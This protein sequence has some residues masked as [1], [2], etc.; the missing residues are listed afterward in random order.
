MFMNK[1]AIF[2]VDGT[3]FNGNL[4]IEF[5]QQLVKDGIFTSEVGIRIYEWY[6]KYKN[7]V[8]DKLIAVDECYKFYNLGLKD[9]DQGLIKQVAEK[10]WANVNSKVFYLHVPL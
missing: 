7:G 10:T 1:L 5:V 2:D 4:G 3:L 8:V 9:K 6:K